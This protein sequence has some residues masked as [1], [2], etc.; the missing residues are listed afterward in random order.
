LFEETTGIPGGLQLTGHDYV[1]LSYSRN[2][3]TTAVTLR[4][5][6][7]RCGLSVFHDVESIRA[8]DL[9]LDRLQ[10]A[11]DG[12]GAFVV[13]VGRDGVKRWI[14]AETQVALSRYFSPHDDTKRLPI[15]P[16][17]LDGAKPDTLPA[18]LRLF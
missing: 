3:G 7:E 10:D 8:S 16:I 1:F 4:A 2:D 18:F 12:C 14:G 17:L 6:L 5:Q 13:L 9:W 11:V 15:Y